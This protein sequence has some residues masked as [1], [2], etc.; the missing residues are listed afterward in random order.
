MASI[1]TSANR[2]TASVFDTIGTTAD[3]AGKLIKTASRAVDM[4][5]AKAQA[6]HQSVVEA[7]VIDMAT[8]QEDLIEE[9]AAELTDRKEQRHRKIFPD[10]DFDRKATYEQ[11]KL[12]IIT[13]LEQAST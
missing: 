8:A 3:A 13:A 7:A 4:L 2:S 6:M 11:M 9:R 5:D 1:I 10:Q 12:K